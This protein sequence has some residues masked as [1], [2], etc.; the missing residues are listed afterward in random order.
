[1]Y[2]NVSPYPCFW[3]ID[4]SVYRGISIRIRIAVSRQPRLL[5]VHASSRGAI[6]GKSWDQ[7]ASPDSPLD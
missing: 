7:G 5:L 2:A 4:V 6:V 3:K 1:M